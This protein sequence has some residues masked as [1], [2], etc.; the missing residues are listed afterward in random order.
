MKHQIKLNE[1]FFEK[2]LAPFPKPANFAMG[3]TPNKKIGIVLPGSHTGKK[4]KPVKRTGMQDMTINKRKAEERA[5]A[6]K[7]NAP[8]AP[9]RVRKPDSTESFERRDR[10]LSDS[11]FRQLLEQRGLA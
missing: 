5:L 1:K 10:N 8:K 3:D 6:K 2:R 11:P 4:P 7:T 9:E